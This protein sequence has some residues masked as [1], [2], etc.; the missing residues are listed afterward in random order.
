MPSPLCNI[1]LTVN[2]SRWIQPIYGAEGQAMIPSSI[3]TG[4]TATLSESIKVRIRPVDHTPPFG[5]K[6][7]EHDDI[8]ITAKMPWLN[9]DLPKFE[10]QK[11][12]DIQYPIELRQYKFLPSLAQ[13]SI[14][15]FTVEVCFLIMYDL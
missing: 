2:Q 15:Q 7:F 13:G 1:P 4:V 6:H 12:I 3:A 8:S 9:R 5:T 11:T 10:Y 14:T